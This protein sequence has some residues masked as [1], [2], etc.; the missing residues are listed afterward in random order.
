[1]RVPL[2]ASVSHPSS[3]YCIL[4]FSW[5]SAVLTLSFRVIPIMRSW[6]SQL[7][8]S[9]Y[10]FG[11]DVF[12]SMRIL[13]P[14]RTCFVYSAFVFHRY[15]FILIMSLS[16]PDMSFL[17]YISAAESAKVFKGLLYQL[18]IDCHF[19]FVSVLLIRPLIL[20]LVLRL[21]GLCPARKQT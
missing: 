5:I 16:Q 6:H 19:A 7:G 21:H 13:K 4:H 11:F 1:M 20:F 9:C 18:I 17:D 12:V 10:L 8:G 2:T 3:P 14:I 15:E